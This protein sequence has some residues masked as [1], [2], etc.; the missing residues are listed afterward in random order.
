MLGCIS[1]AT[2]SEKSE[3]KPFDFEIEQ[4]KLSVCVF[5][6]NFA[7]MNELRNEIS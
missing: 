7:G 6:Q 3:M 4:Y 5:Y 2:V 1:T